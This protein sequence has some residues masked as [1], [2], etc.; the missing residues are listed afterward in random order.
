LA[1]VLLSITS[2]QPDS[3]LGQVAAELEDE[4]YRSGVAARRSRKTRSPV[5]G[6]APPATRN[7]VLSAFVGVAVAAFHKA[8]QTALSRDRSL[9][10][11]LKLPNGP[12]ITIDARNI[13]STELSADI[14]AALG[15]LG[16]EEQSIR[17][18]EPW[19]TPGKP[20]PKP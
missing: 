7:I 20:P 18:T 19:P 2:D 9:R 15:S 5:K 11:K 3:A 10:L 8:A 12:E 14:E 4:L 1:Q 17:P 13:A 6:G 16:R